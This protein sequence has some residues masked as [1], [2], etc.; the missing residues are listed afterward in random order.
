MKPFSTRLPHNQA[1]IF[2]VSAMSLVLGLMIASAVVTGKEIQQS[3]SRLRDADLEERVFS[4]NLNLQNQYRELLAEVNKLRRENTQLQNVLSEGTK[5]SEVLNQQLQDAKAFA[6]LTEIQGPGVLV[7]LR[8]GETAA[9]SLRE[10]LSPQAAND[11]LLN[12]KIIHDQDILKVVNELWAAGAE[13]IS[14]NNFRLGPTSSI[15]CVGPVV[16]VDGVK[17]ASPIRIRAIGDPQTL[18]GGLKMPGGIYDEIRTVDPSMIQV[19]PI[20]MM[21]LP[22]YTGPTTRRYAVPATHEK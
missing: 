15:R 11:L 16:H 9:S 21:K 4:G 17:V 12:E 22:A 14:I 18:T 3:K 2:P 1:W 7:S 5:G 20:K 13:A 10:N 6:C 8:D 19:E